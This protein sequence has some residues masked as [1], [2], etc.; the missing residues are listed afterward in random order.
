MNQKIFSETLYQIDSKV[1][2]VREA[3][4]M[5]YAQTADHRIK[6]EGHQLLIE[7]LS[8]IESSLAKLQKTLMDSATKHQFI[9]SARVPQNNG[10]SSK[11]NNTGQS[12]RNKNKKLVGKEEQIRAFLRKK[13]PKTEIAKICGVS[14]S[15]IHKFI[16]E[17]NLEEG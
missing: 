12:K 13:I 17:Q 5:F 8:N 1:R 14:A 11:T 3:G 15:S 7:T 10:H 16:K 2:I 4:R 6:D 9:G